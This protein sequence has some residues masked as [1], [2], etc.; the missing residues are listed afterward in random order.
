MDTITDRRRRMLRTVKT[1][2]NAA[3]ELNQNATSIYVTCTPGVG[4]KDE[5]CLYQR[6]CLSA[7]DASTCWL[8]RPVPTRRALVGTTWRGFHGGVDGTLLR[9]YIVAV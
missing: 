2:Q 8:W 4:T 5:L 6:V 3:V 1:S 9:T 7:W